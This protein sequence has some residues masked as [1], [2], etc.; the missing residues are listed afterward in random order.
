MLFPKYNKSG[1]Q[2]LYYPSF[3]TNAQNRADSYLMPALGLSKQNVR[4]PWC[5]L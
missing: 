5:Y 4:V 3:N 2:I 1:K